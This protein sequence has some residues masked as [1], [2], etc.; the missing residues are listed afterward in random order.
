MDAYSGNQF[1][2]AK[3]YLAFSLLYQPYD[4]V[5]KAEI[6]FLRK[7]L[8]VAVDYGEITPDDVRWAIESTDLS[9]LS[10]QDKKE[11]LIW[12]EWTGKRQ[13]GRLS[14]DQARE[15]RK[16]AYDCGRLVNCGHTL[17]ILD[18]ADAFKS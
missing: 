12:M 1:Q 3:T 11:S 5:R 15:L 13:I 6:A 9:E 2:D 4:P 8:F 16:L 18:I 10:D 14:R 17:A 7:L